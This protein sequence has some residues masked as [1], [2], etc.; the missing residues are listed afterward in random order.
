MDEIDI[1]RFLKIQFLHKLAIKYFKI[2]LGS[3]Q[4]QLHINVGLKS[5]DNFPGCGI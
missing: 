2:V 1:F 5:A 3:R 4:I